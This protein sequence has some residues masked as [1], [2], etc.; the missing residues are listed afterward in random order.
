MITPE[1]AVRNKSLPG[2]VWI[3]PAV[4]IA[5]AKL[6]FKL[7][8]CSIALGTPDCSVHLPLRAASDKQSQAGSQHQQ[9]ASTSRQPMTAAIA[10]SVHPDILRALADRI[11]LTLPKADLG[12][13]FL[14]AVW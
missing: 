9:A 1:A 2:F 4:D 7:V 10:M 5:Q 6:R 3:A 13:F 14:I 11:F 8:R 12:V